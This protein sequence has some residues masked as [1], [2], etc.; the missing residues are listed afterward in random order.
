M[1]CQFHHLLDTVLFDLCSAGAGEPGREVSLSTGPPYAP[2]SARRWE[3]Q[4]QLA[5]A[6]GAGDAQAWGSGLGAAAAAR[7][8]NRYT[9]L[10]GGAGG[11]GAVPKAP[12]WGCRAHRH[13]KKGC[14]SPSSS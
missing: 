3:A 8:P 9:I 1:C 14:R 11:L 12:C 4:A 7:G 13:P 5:R 10:N 6:P 2:G